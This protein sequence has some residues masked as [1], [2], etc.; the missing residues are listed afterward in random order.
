MKTKIVLCTLILI[1]VNLGT[2]AQSK[3]YN[4]AMLKWVTYFNDSLLK[5]QN[6]E[7]LMNTFERIGKI[8]KD[9]WLPY[10]YAAHC[11]TTAAGLEKDNNIADELTAKALGLIDI[12]DQLSKNNDEA[13]VLRAYV[14]F[15]Q[16]NV[17]FMG[18]GIKNSNYAET[19]LKKAL[20]IN[21]KNPRAYFLLGM[22]LYAR[23]DQYGGNK[24]KACEYFAKSAELDI[25]QED[26]LAPIWQR[27]PIEKLT[28]KCT[29]INLKSQ[30]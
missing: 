18:R 8:E 12:I 21:D 11:A 16:I 6:S 14:A 17:D 28:K 3:K 26:V 2:F 22:G 5:R 29:E 23:G 10:Y 19:V 4:E 15:T 1:I 25:Q 30:K 24:A 9:K 27:S 7:F 13:Y 20:S